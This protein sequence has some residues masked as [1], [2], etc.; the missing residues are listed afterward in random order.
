MSKGEREGAKDKLCLL[1]YFAKN[2]ALTDKPGKKTKTKNMHGAN[3]N[4][5]GKLHVS[6]L[7]GNRV[8]I[9]LSTKLLQGRNCGL[10]FFESPVTGI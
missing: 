6:A 1:H 5:I 8:Y 2:L 3:T 9:P 4:F 7:Y 10:N